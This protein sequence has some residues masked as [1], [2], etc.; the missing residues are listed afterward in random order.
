VIHPVTVPPHWSVPDQTSQPK[1]HP[2]AEASPWFKDVVD[3]RWKDVPG[4]TNLAVGDVSQHNYQ[5]LAQIA[6]PALSPISAQLSTT[7]VLPSA[8][9]ASKTAIASVPEPKPPTSSVPKTRQK[10]V[11]LQAATSVT[12]AALSFVKDAVPTPAPQ[13][14]PA[15]SKDDEAKVKPSGTIRLR[16][17]QEAEAKRAEARKTAEREREKAARSAAPPIASEDVQSFITSWEVS[18]S[19][20]WGLPTSQAG[21]RN[22]NTSKD[23]PISSPNASTTPWTTAKSQQMKKSMKE[24]QE[25]EERRK[26]VAM[27]E[28]AATTARKAHENISKVCQLLLLDIVSQCL[29]LA[30]P[31]GNPWTTVG[32]GGKTA[33]SAT[34]PTRPA[35]S[36][37]NTSA[38]SASGTRANGAMSARSPQ[39]SVGAKAQPPSKSDEAVVS[40]S[41]EFLKWLTDSL[42][43]LNSSVNCT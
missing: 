10:P 21:A 31:V 16:E 25:E 3:D 2:P 5:E 20:S 7:S 9:R 14:K 18:T 23:P 27:K 26:K 22:A 40:P 41:H 38:S 37:P 42:K 19:Q 30:Q 6:F 8:E 33:P 36:V 1:H 12:Q 17:I 34:V 32:P 39:T 43:G 24:I 11:P 15:W 35:V 28:T 4:P 13:V 29:V